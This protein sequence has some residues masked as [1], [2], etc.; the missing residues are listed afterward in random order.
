MT[1]LTPTQLRVLR[2]ARRGTLT[3]DWSNGYPFSVSDDDIR[4]VTSVAKRLAEDL[5]LIEIGVRRQF[6]T[7]WRPTPA[8]DEV[9]SANPEE[10]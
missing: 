4:G 5:H 2:A 6:D 1:H 8:G 3:R 10:S 9:L 7:V